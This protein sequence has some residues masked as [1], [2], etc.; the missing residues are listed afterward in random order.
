M[1]A[2]KSSKISSLKFWIVSASLIIIIAGLKNAS[3]IVTLFLLSILMTAISLAPFDW[4]KKKGVPAALAL[5]ILLIFLTLIT[6][7]LVGL[8]GS[9]LNNF[10]ATIPSYQVK[11]EG[12]WVPLQEK[13]LEYGLIESDFDALAAINPGKALTLAGNVFSGFSSLLSN[14]FLIVLV[15]IFMLMEVSSFKNKLAFISPNSLGSMDKVVES[16]KKYFGIKTLTSLL[17]GVLVSTGLAILGVDFPILWGALAF[18]LN[19]IPNIGSIIAA[20]PA[21]LLAFLQL[22]VWVGG[23]TIILFFLVN[24][25][26]GSILEPRL[27][28]KSLGLSSFVVFISL[29]IWGSILGTVGMLIAT[30]LTITLKIILDSSDDTRNIGILLGDT[31]AIRELKKSQE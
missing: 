17:T 18:L 14:S 2:I 28:G 27:M 21:V 10:L 22:P 23:A 31:S 19:F 25:G 20:V 4:L 9:S 1:T 8:L 30:P 6:F 3:D 24:F 7:G 13:L 16:L 11:L 5:L 15:F 26:I 29:I 12:I